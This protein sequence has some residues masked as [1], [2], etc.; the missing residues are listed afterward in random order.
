MIRLIRRSK[1][2]RVKLQTF[3][4]IWLWTKFYQNRTVAS[5]GLLTVAL[6]I[7]HFK[8]G[9]SA[10]LLVKIVKVS[11]LLKDIIYCYSVWAHL[12]GHGHLPRV[13]DC[14]RDFGVAV[15]MIGL[16]TANGFPAGCRKHNYS[17]TESYLRLQASLS[18]MMSLSNVRVDNYFFRHPTLQ[19][20]D[21]FFFFSA[22]G[23]KWKVWP[24]L[25][26]AGGQLF[27]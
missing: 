13:K 2:L 7:K 23:V 4:Q 8:T 26:N 18:P 1:V 6:N 19:C 25:L 12:T 22:I 24:I 5:D 16:R 21:F 10:T 20:F 27:S 9:I 14:L 11:F 17:P 15:I 3:T